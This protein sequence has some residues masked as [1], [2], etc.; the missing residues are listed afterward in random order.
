MARK[1]EKLEAE[2]QRADELERRIL[3]L[4]A[5]VKAARQAERMKIA[6]E[7]LKGEE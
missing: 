5:E 4:I 3:Q 1:N 2:K 7:I 6:A